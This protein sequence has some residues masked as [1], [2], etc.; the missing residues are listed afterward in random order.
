MTDTCLKLTNLSKRITSH[1]LLGKIDLSLPAKKRVALLGL[2]GAGKSSLLRLIVG[3]TKPDSGSAEFCLNK[4]QHQPTDHFIKSQLGYQADTMLAIDHLSGLDYLKLCGLSKGLSQEIT[5]KRIR[6]YRDSW[7]LTNCLDIPM[8]S[9]SKGNLQKLAIFQAFL[10]KPKFLIF[11]EPCQ[12]LDPIEQNNFNQLIKNLSDFE[13]C[14]FSTHNVDHALGTSDQ[15]LVFK[16]LR[17]I[18]HFT[19]IPNREILLALL[20]DKPHEADDA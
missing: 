6:D 19:S 4:K 8:A 20:A 10:N 16:D 7:P 11:D 14:L 15:I 12:S 18:K 13:L 3:E 9:L 2:N 17:L 1:K 5:L